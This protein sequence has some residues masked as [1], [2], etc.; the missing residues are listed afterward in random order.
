MKGRARE[1]GSVC[2]RE[3]KREDGGEGEKRDHA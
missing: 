2:K 1:S 3:R